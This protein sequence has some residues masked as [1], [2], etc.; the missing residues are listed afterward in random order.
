MW[1]IYFLPL[2]SLFLLL[3]KRLLYLRRWNHFPGLSSWT[4]WPMIGHGNHLGE[5]PLSRLSQM[6]EKFGDIFR[7]D[8]GSMPTVILCDF[9]DIKDFFK[10]ESFSGRPNPLIPS[11][12]EIRGGLDEEGN[13]SSIVA[14]GYGKA[15][16]E[17]RQF[18]VNQLSRLGMGKNRVMSH[19]LEEEAEH[20]RNLLRSEIEEK[21]SSAIEVTNLFVMVTN[22]SI[23]RILTGSRNKQTDPEIISLTRTLRRFFSAFDPGSIRNLLQ[24][25]CLPFAK[26]LKFLGMSNLL[27]EAA[28]IF[29]RMKRLASNAQPNPDG[30]FPDRYLAEISKNEAAGNS[31]STFFGRKG[32]FQIH[33]GLFDLFL[34]G[35]DKASTFMEWTVLYLIAHPDVQE[36]AFQEIED[37]IGL[38]RN[39]TLEDREKTP[40]C[41]AVLEEVLRKSPQMYFNMPHLTTRDVRVKGL[42]FP[43]HTQVFA[44]LGPTMNDPVHFPEPQKFRPERF[45]GENGD[46][47]ANERVIPFSV[48]RRKCPGQAMGRAQL[49]ILFAFTLQAFKFK[50][51]PGTK[52][53]YQPVVGRVF[54]PKPFK[55]IIEKR[56]RYNA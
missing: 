33:G 16:K 21:S 15:F 6:R 53:D 37:N 39:P 48:G 13:I 25:N 43:R 4:S 26:A 23:W 9:D 46:F 52:P 29:D 7:C 11:L 31:D 44:F 20:F 2:L 54:H 40:Y 32:R 30:N 45:L 12:A 28:P 36:K 17:H 3:L 35:T 50:P 27:D 1:A 38:N 14:A 24:V 19:I 5:D 41:L 47:V 8:I 42:F 51:V 22:N 18:A 34:G 49:Y 55:A 10:L 56:I